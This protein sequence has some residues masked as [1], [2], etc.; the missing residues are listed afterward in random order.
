MAET[1]V[2]EQKKYSE[3]KTT[4]NSLI[5]FYR[6]LFAMWVVYYHS[7]F[8]FENHYFNYGYIAVEFFF[9]VSGFYILR[10]IDKLKTDNFFVGL[11][12]LIWGRIK[13]LGL[14]LIIGSIF[15]I[16]YM[17]IEG[18]FSLFGYLW[19]IPTVLLAFMVMYSLRRLIK[20]NI[21]FALV[22]IGITVVSY[23]VL[24]YPILQG[25]GVYRALGGVSIGV[26]I[27]LIPKKI[28]NVKKINFNWVIT[29]LL[30][31]ITLIL[32]G[33][34]KTNMTIEYLLIFLV[35]PMLVWFTNTLTFNNKVL[36]FLGSLGF[37]LYAYQCV[38]RVFEYYITI[39][40]YWL[41]IMLVTMV[42]LDKLIVG[43]YNKYINKQD[44][45]KTA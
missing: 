40:Q 25:S 32:V 42:L 43:L 16:W 19:Y 38:L 33:V 31:L 37:G 23:V 20:N 39:E 29:V 28:F 15:V 14:P 6:F 3:T 7:Y 22:V 9:I 17:F 26:L 27:S 35:M 45:F 10:S 24:Y 12:K 8:L 5:E 44:N 34:H 21:V 4:R 1:I 41:F 13:A 11:W 2:Q 30:I 18:Q 36:N